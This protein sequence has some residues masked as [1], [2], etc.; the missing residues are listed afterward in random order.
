LQ[1]AALEMAASAAWA[2]MLKKPSL[3]QA[4]R[5]SKRGENRASLVGDD[6]LV[7]YCPRTGQMSMLSRQ[8][9]SKSVMV[10]QQ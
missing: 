10:V 1:Y 8:S 7:I 3:D 6:E 2:Q 4:F 9:Q 5:W